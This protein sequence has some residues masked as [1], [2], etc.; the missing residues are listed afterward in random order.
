M[1]KNNSVHI[2]FFLVSFLFLTFVS[3][4]QVVVNQDLVPFT[5]KQLLLSPK[6][7]LKSLVSLKNNDEYTASLSDI[8]SYQ[9]ELDGYLSDYQSDYEFID[10]INVSI[11]KEKVYFAGTNDY[12]KWDLLELNRK[13]EE[14]KTIKAD[15][16]YESEKFVDIY[17]PVST[18]I[19]Y[20]VCNR[21]CDINVIDVTTGEIVQE[22][23]TL[24]SNLPGDRAEYISEFFFD[25]A[26]NIVGYKNYNP[27]DN[28][29]YTIDMNADS[30]AASSLQIV[31]LET[32]GQYFKFLFYYPESQMMLFQSDKKETSQ[33]NHPETEYFLYSVNRPALVLVDIN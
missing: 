12:K 3:V 24:I 6:T 26:V 5:Y 7:L 28:K 23:P 27:G 30:Q 15:I 9:V 10:V 20:P 8:E 1:I 13:T 14:I 11:D 2:F 33:S 32:A 25:E 18:R 21:G 19:A 17:Q 4:K 31:H 29:F 22:K 16:S